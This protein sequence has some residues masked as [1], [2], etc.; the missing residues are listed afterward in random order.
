MKKVRLGY[1]QR[2]ILQSIV[3]H[4]ESNFLPREYDILLKFGLSRRKSAPAYRGF[5]NTSGGRTCQATVART[6][7]NLMDRGFICRTKAVPTT[8]TDQKSWRYLIN[9][10]GLNAL[11]G[12][13]SVSHQPTKEVIKKPIEHSMNIKSNLPSVGQVT[14][15]HRADNTPSEPTFGDLNLGQVGVRRLPNKTVQ[16]VLCGEDCYIDLADSRQLYHLDKLDKLEEILPSGSIIT[17]KTK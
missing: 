7:R 10:K 13:G 1:V 12:I 8:Y 11:K 17:F 4:I 5:L 3:D 2:H 14:Y 16:Y 15:V 9:P 6:L